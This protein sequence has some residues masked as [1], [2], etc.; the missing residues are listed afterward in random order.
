[1]PDGGRR[2]R[3]MI[4]AWAAAWLVTAA[5]VAATGYASR[6]PDSRLY[7]GISAH[8]GQEPVARWIAP[9]WGGL[10]GSTGL[11]CE[12][13]AGI[14]V[15]P[16]A[17]VRLG[18]PAGQAAYA[19][20]ALYEVCAF[21]LIG[22][23]AAAFVPRREAAALTWILQLLPIALVFHVR[24]N[25][26]YAV[27]AGTLLSLYATE[28]SR[29]RSR[30]IPGMIAGFCAVLLTKGV[31]ALAVPV[32]C[33]IWLVARSRPGERSWRAWAGVVAMPF[34]GVLVTWGYEAAYV[35][36]AGQSFLD[37]YV[38]RQLPES[39][40]VGGASILRA[41]Y[42]ALWYF[43][44]IVWYAFPWSVPAIA[45]AGRAIGRGCWRP[46]PDEGQHGPAESGIRRHEGAWF[47]LVSALVLTL[48]L[49]L[50]HRKADRYLFAVYFLVAAVGAVA[51]VRRVAWLQRVVERLDRP[52][53]PAA[54]F[55]GLFVIRLMTTGV[56]P[57]FTFWRS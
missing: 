10:W 25:H 14:F 30:W 53:V 21:A 1:M 47:A 41:G 35:R 45:M 43:G 29:T 27:L 19:M 23:V 55:V 39:A 42:N 5:L 44:R 32:A 20:T 52:W 12:N 4:V 46:R 33:A 7:A 56:L 16:A 9:E 15:L 26:E 22:L 49:S 34:A 24:A 38:A 11:F 6:D 17:A 50:A 37:V 28:Q 57:E 40:L 8:L 31:F 36:V 13:P 54:V 48:G 51:G 3:V 2:A 18:Y